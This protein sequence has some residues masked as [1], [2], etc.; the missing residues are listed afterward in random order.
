[1]LSL[2]LDAAKNIGLGAVVVLAIL[3]LVVASVI[4]NVMVKVVTIVLVIGIGVAVWT[5]R[6][7]LQNC[8][9]RAKDRV[10]AGSTS[11]V[12]C[13]FFNK[14]ITVIA[15]EPAPTTPAG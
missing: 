6:T 15:E 14:T 7:S 12:V 4:R 13:K 10:V 3:A 2:T 9:E 11:A 5:Q 8:A 1:M